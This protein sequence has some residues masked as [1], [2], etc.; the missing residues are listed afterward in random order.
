MRISKLL[1]IATSKAD[2]FNQIYEAVKDEDVWEKIKLK[3][4]AEKEK[5]VQAVALVD[6]QTYELM[7]PP[8]K[9]LKS[10]SKHKLSHENLRKCDFNNPYSLISSEIAPK[11]YKS[12][13]WFGVYYEYLSKEG[14]LGLGAYVSM[15]N[16]Y[17]I[18]QLTDERKNSEK[19]LKNII[20]E[21]WATTEE[22]QTYWKNIGIE[23]DEIK[24][25]I[26]EGG[27]LRLKYPLELRAGEEISDIHKRIIEIGKLSFI[28]KI[29]ELKAFWKTNFLKTPDEIK[30]PAHSID[31]QAKRE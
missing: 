31:A 3:D 19:K 5:I 16:L 28:Q 29:P 24:D 4:F 30:A 14:P 17:N 1:E 2:D 25:Y 20:G 22:M 23:D 18:N 11:K 21:E 15:T 26:E 27:M 13:T 9:E 7:V 6:E 8:L 10:I 12:W